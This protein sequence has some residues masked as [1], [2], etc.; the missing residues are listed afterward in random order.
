MITDDM[1][2]VTNIRTCHSFHQGQ[3]SPATVSCPFDVIDICSLLA[4]DLDDGLICRA[5]DER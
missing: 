5:A 1:L 4:Y 3:Q 2:D